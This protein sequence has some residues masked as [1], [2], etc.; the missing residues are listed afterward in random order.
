MAFKLLYLD[1]RGQ[2]SG[3]S[4]VLSA[5]KKKEE[6]RKRKGEGRGREERDDEDAE[7]K[8]TYST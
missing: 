7:Q 5:K 4:R 6:G 3:N 1:Y 8:E 2:D